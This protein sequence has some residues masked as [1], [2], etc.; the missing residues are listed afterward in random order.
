[1]TTE[2][3]TSSTWLA[4]H[5]VSIL[6]AITGTALFLIAFVAMFAPAA[7]FL[8]DHDTDTR[9]LP[10]WLPLGV[11]LGYFAYIGM[12]A[13]VA[14]LLWRLWLARDFSFGQARSEIARLARDDF[15]PVIGLG[16]AWVCVFVGI[17]VFVG[18]VVF[19]LRVATDVF[20][21]WLGLGVVFVLWLGLGAV[22][23]GVAGLLAA[24][25]D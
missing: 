16:L 21:L 25:A 12:I 11:A 10:T 22:C 24:P 5:L 15:G 7:L 23:N 4:H 6:D 17:I 1:M 2:N 8:A 3:T 20:G 13:F 18:I 14:L 19:V 9:V